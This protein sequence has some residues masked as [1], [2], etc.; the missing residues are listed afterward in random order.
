MAAV[1]IGSNDSAFSSE[2]INKNGFTLPQVLI[3]AVCVLLNIIDGFDVTT[4]AVSKTAIATDLGLTASQL[5]ILDGVALAGMCLGAMFLGA[6]SDLIGR[7]RMILVSISI[8][9]VAMLLTAMVQNFQQFFLIRL[10]TGL[11]VGSMLAS[12]ATIVSEYSPDKYKSLAVT[13]ATA[14][15]PMGAML[16][17]TF[18][19]DLIAVW[20]W[21]GVFY[22]G[23]AAT[24]CMTVVAF[25]FLP[26]S[27]QFLFAK[28]PKNALTAI[29][30]IMR[31]L[32]Y[33]TVEQ[34][35]A[36]ENVNG[37]GVMQTILGLFKNLEALFREGQWRKTLLLWLTFFLCFI[38][39]Y[40]LMSWI[41]YLVE[42]SGFT[43]Q[44]GGTAFAIFNIGG[45]LGV[46]I[47]GFMS[48][49]LNLTVMVGTFLALSS[50]VMIIFAY[51][52]ASYS[53]L[54]LIIFLIGVLQQGGFT[55]L[56]AC[57]AKMYASE[58]RATGLGWAIGLGRIGAVV[59]PAVAGVLIDRG[60]NMETNFIIFAIP[61][62]LGGL[63][64]Y[65]LRLR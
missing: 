46:I 64:A 55:G 5:G 27:L 37:A 39:L 28:Q 19:P 65:T 15:Y 1:D 25:L 47:L 44:Q 18:G 38:T 21:Q 41:P 29:N 23:A 48:T 43:R 62:L 12:I 22:F 52:K 33:A 10:I 11:G 59:G 13:L 16:G 3:I 34:L 20:G 63:M 58:F 36:R 4:M 31:R 54:L 61:M 26:E 50:V 14:G 53:V 8:I 17:G 30:K 24:A 6:L 49:R 42:K 32:N 35:P 9:T 51:T 2:I 60:V 56:Y 40:F 7:R 45:V 57:A